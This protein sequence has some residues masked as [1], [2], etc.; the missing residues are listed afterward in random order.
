MLGFQTLAVRLFPGIKLTDT[1][2]A[3]TG[4]LLMFIIPVRWGE[5]LDFLLNWKDIRRLPWDVLL[6]FGGGL[7]LAAIIRKTGLA[8]WIA[9]NFQ[10]LMG[11]PPSPPLPWWF[12]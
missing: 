10:V 12:R 2:I 3:L 6:L 11:Y 9:S 8:E 7:S 4:G 5:R 1:A